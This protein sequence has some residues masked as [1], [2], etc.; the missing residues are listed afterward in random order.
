MR[1]HLPESGGMTMIENTFID[2]FMPSSSGDFVKIY[3][4]LMRCAQSGQTDVSVAQIADALNYTESDV[5]R[6]M[7]YWQKCSCLEL[8]EDAEDE[9]SAAAPFAVPSSQAQSAAG[10]AS[11]QSAGT[12][13]SAASSAAEAVTGQPVGV[14]FSQAQ[15]AVVRGA[16]SQNAGS[17]ITEFRPAQK[18]SKEDIRSLVFVA[19]NYLGRPLSQPEKQTLVYFL[20]DLGMDIDLIDYLL[21]Y[22][23][24]MNHTSFWYIKKVALNWAEQGITSAEQARR[25]GS[26][27]RKEYYTIF[28]G[29]GIRDHEPTPGEKE[30]MDRWLGEYALSMDVI[31]LACRRTILQIGKAQFAYTDSILKSWHDNNVRTVEDVEALD[32]A[33]ELS[34]KK[35]QEADRQSAA[36]STAGRFLNFE[37]SGTDWDAVADSVM[38]AQ[39]EQERVSQES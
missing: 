1:V 3:L 38:R 13:F 22:C 5:K 17:K 7:G 24:S 28:R 14:Q 15:S 34:L 8:V 9:K 12:Q 37:S 2:Q 32:K 4:Y 21:D 29:L 25:E 6:A 27:C 18:Y 16:D 35:V 36:H 30:F 10:F 23:V 31:L 33:H 20:T 11:G 39:E 26:S 19:E